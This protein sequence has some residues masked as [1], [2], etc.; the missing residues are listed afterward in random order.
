M[1]NLLNP[2][3]ASWFDITSYY[4]SDIVVSRL[5]YL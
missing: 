4:V 5:K 1:L 2:N 3:N